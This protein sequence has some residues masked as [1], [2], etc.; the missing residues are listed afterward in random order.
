[1]NPDKKIIINGLLDRVNASPYLIVIDYTGLTV[2]QFTELRNR[3]DAGGANCTVAKNS[4]MRKALAEAGMPDIGTD[5][6]GQM[7]Y[8][9]G[10]SE[11]FAA[12]KVIKNFEKEFKK[13]EMKVGILG[14]A[15]LDTA[16]LQAIAD[17]P[18]REAVLSQLLA[19]ILE[20][21]TRIARIVQNKFNPEGESSSE[22]TP[23]VEAVAEEA[24]A[25]EVAAEAAPAAEAEAEAP[26]A[27]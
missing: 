24:P 2:K 27:E 1:M 3:L 10:S 13:P 7:A 12:A 9:M 25:A 19:T 14:N 6:V 18:S 20:P 11:V 21:A 22:E 16:K 23:A 4:Y 15:V 8:V 5:L 26:A 17:I